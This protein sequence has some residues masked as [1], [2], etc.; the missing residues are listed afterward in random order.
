M[1]ELSF[2]NT[3]IYLCLFLIVACI[4]LCQCYE[5]I[6]MTTPKMNRYDTKI[7][8]KNAARLCD[9]AENILIAS[10]FIFSIFLVC[11]YVYIPK[12]LPL[13]G[14]C[15]YILG[16]CTSAILLFF[17]IL[18]CIQFLQLIDRKLTKL[19]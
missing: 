12:I 3:A 10:C 13:Q 8:I 19:F 4:I 6:Y 7:F 11:K 15:I 14:K 17:F 5:Y 9:I 1:L 18:Y 2:L 16:A